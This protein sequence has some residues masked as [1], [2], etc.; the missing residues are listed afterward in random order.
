M[1]TNLKG[2]GGVKGFLLLH[3][4]KI[5]IGIVGFFAL[6]IVYKSFNLPKLD[7]KHQADAL[8]DEITRT[9]NDLKGFTWDRAVTD[10]PDK[11]KKAQAIAPQTNLNVEPKFY[12]NNDDPN[13]K[14]D[15]IDLAVVA[16]MIVRTDPV[17]LNALE[18]R[19]TGGSGPLAFVDEEIRKERQLRMAQEAQEQAK[20]EEEKAK[21][22][23]AKRAKEAA[24]GPGESRKGRGPG[25]EYVQ[26][27]MDPNHPKRRLIE[28]SV[29]PTGIQLQGDERIERAY[30]ACVVRQGSDSRAAQ[31]ISGRLR[32]SP[33]L[34]RDSRLPT[35]PRLLRPAGR[36]CARKGI[37]VEA[38]A[39]VR[40]PA[41]VD[42]RQYAVEQRAESRHWF[43]GHRQIVQ[44]CRAVLGRRRRTRNRRRTVHGTSTHA[45]T[46]AA[47]GPRFRR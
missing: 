46:S 44:R 3:G 9:S 37:G 33:R 2:A 23:E 18:V 42:C 47:G 8:R 45:T 12:V 31:A 41:K 1:A 28:G 43:A 29:R 36:G 30:W 39:V 5:A 27:I 34:R 6:W 7:D 22:E 20:K 4:E 17:L 32:K 21:K 38:S 24:G 19:A 16:P 10:H 26:E 40:R 15:P 13:G 25:Q 11:V 14:T 35:I